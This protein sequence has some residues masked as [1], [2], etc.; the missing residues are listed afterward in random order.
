MSI[1]FYSHF[2]S[3]QVS[4]AYVNVIS[5]IVFCSLNFSFFKY[6]CIFTKIVA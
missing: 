4:D 6:V 5:I 3:I 1:S 2:V